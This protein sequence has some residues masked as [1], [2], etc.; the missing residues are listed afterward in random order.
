MPDGR[1]PRVEA[2]LLPLGL[3]SAV[4]CGKEFGAFV[5]QKSDEYTRIIH[6]ANVKVE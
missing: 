6:D 3:Y 2:K 4:V 1:R 5:K